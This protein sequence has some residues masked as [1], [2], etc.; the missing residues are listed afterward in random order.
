MDFSLVDHIA[1]IAT[2]IG[3][4]LVIAGLLDLYRERA[5][6]MRNGGNG[7]ALCF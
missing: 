5:L 3:F 4:P 6:N 7:L 2:L 1:S